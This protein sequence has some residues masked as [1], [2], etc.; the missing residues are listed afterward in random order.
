MSPMTSR[1]MLAVLTSTAALTLAGIT[2]ALAAPYTD[3][4]VVETTDPSPGV[5]DTIPV[6][7]TGFDANETLYVE[8]HS[9]PILLRTVQADAAGAVD[10]TVTLPPD[11]RCAHTIVVRDATS[12]D[13]ASTAIFIGDPDDCDANGNTGA[14]NS[15]SGNS[16]YGNTGNNNSGYGNHGNN[17]S[18]AGNTGNNN[19]GYGNTGDGN[20]G[21]GNT[22]G[23]GGYADNALSDSIVAANADW[24]HVSYAAAT[25]ESHAPAVAAGAVAGLAAVGGAGFLVRRRRQSD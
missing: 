8:L 13:V 14:G 18:G 17:N 7:M 21:Y 5:G 6:A 9:T 24:G 20:S 10:T 11:A 15:G 16:G 12:E 1:T 23:G 22:G 25:P 19:S 3:E 2:P 4:P